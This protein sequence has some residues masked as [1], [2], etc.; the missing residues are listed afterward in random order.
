MASHKDFSHDNA[1]NPL[2][3]SVDA[4]VAQMPTFQALTQLL[5][6]LILLPPT[7]V[8]YSR[9]STPVP[10]VPNPSS[11]MPIG[12]PPSRTSWTRSSPPRLCRPRRPSSWPRAFLLLTR[13]HSVPSWISCGSLPL[14]GPGQ[15]AAQVRLH[16]SPPIESSRIL[17]RFRWRGTGEQCDPF[18][19]LVPF[20][21]SGRRQP[22]ELPWM[23]HKTEC[24]FRQVHY[25]GFGTVGAVF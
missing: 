7:T 2:F 24:E 4:S 8:T 25:Q 10:T 19:Q 14:P 17:L 13:Q 5:V 16:L 1:P 12:M 9:P 6:G 21:S 11:T 18:W 15:L 3:T 20:P 22:A 23:V